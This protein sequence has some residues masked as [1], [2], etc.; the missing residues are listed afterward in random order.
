MWVV[1]A[2]NDPQDSILHTSHGEVMISRRGVPEET[3]STD[4][5]TIA[6]ASTLSLCGTMP[7]KGAADADP[8]IKQ[9]PWRTYQPT[10][11]KAASAETESMQQLESRVASAVLAK[12]PGNSMERD[13]I[14]DRIN[15]LESQVSQLM[16]KQGGLENQFLDFTQ[17]SNQQ[18]GVMQSQI[19]TQSQQI[20]GQLES[21]AQSIQAMFESQ[22]SQIRNLL[23]KRPRDDN[24]E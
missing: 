18:F 8:W 15:S 23:S 16:A 22:M 2:V 7:A 24:M 4:S 14:P 21:Q 9:D 13:D 10:S 17:H 11:V 19:T 20:H 6:A 12:I 1:Q 5:N 3:R